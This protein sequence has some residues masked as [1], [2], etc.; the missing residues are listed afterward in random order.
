MPAHSSASHF[1]QAPAAGSFE[2]ILGIIIKGDEALHMGQIAWRFEP[3]EEQL[4]EARAQLQAITFCSEDCR[5][6][7]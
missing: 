5:A 2:R 3:S 4:Q 1:R 6:Q 7:P